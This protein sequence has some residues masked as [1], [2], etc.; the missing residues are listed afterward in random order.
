M[1]YAKVLKIIIKGD[2]YVMEFTIYELLWFFAIYSFLGWCTEVVYAAVNTGKFVNRGF[3]NGPVCSIY[4]FAI[5]G[6]IICLAPLKENLLI[7]FI[8]SV[9]LTSFLEFVTGFVLEKLFHDK[10]WDYSGLPYN[11]H[12]YICLKFSLLWGMAC[13]LVINVIHPMIYRFVKFTHSSIGIICIILFILLLIVDTGTT[14]T[15]ILNYQKKLRLMEE[16]ADKL[17]V[18]S[19]EFG[20]NI[21]NGV[22]TAMEKREELK[23]NIDEQKQKFE[24]LK[25]K[26][27]NLIEQNT[28]VQRRLMKAFPQLQNGKYKD[29]IEKIKHH[30]MGM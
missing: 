26:L 16:I 10:W 5:V 13:V 28:F 30:N 8:G 3:L 12:G 11:I 23:E 29:I 25:G 1:K 6:I 15:G 14:A 2:G 20:N 22:L 21:S 9:F 27:K 17:K 24:E 19:N 18:L 7:L 4:G